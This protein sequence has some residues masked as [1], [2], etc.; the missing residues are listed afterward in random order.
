MAN[1]VTGNYIRAHR[2]RCG[3]S[4]RELGRLIG[5][6]DDGQVARHERSK[7]IPGL[8]T[9]LAY[10]IVFQIEVSS[11]FAGFQSSVA[12]AVQMNLED[13]RPDLHNQADGRRLSAV[14]PQKTEWLH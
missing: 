3:L 9:A 7:T 14:A 10:G 4:Q 8:L 13:F 12:Q 6:T 5:Y 2:R 11:I 1:Q